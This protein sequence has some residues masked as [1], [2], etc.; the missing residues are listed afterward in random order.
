MEV[1]ALIEFLGQNIHLFF[2]ELMN[3]NKLFMQ[4]MV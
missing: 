2:E 4:K 3:L 1:S